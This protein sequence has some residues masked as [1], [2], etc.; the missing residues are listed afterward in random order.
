MGYGVTDIPPIA[1]KLS[2]EKSLTA[3][4]DDD[5]NFAF[6]DLVPGTY[7]VPEG[8]WYGVCNR[9]IYLKS[10]LSMCLKAN[11]SIGLPAFP[12]QS[13]VNRF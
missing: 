3:T 5:H 13:S 1:V 11:R 12:L 6:N 4:T 8:V 9:Q 2:G 7:T 10:S